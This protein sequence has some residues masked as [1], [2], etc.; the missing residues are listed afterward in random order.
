MLDRCKRLKA[1]TSACKAGGDAVL[2]MPLAVKP[3]RN[4]P[5]S[6]ASAVG[7]VMQSQNAK[8]WMLC[9]LLTGQAEVSYDGTRELR[10]FV[11]VLLRP[12]MGSHCVHVLHG[13]EEKEN[14]GNS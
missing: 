13:S 12:P 9:C 6:F 4:A 1:D 14:P 11:T 3:A 10:T 7:N 2:I 8:A 5:P